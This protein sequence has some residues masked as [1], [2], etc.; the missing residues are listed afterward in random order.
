MKVVQLCP[1]L[2]DP[3][4]YAVH[5]ILQTSIQE[6][7]AF[8]FPGDLPNPGIKL[9]SPVLQEDSLPAE[10]QGKSLD[11]IYALIDISIS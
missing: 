10:P 4:G 3:M 1:V 5:G 6:W 9:R 7:V 8:P 2:W 11:S